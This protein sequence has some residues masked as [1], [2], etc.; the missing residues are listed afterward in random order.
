M[1]TL[2]M[3][4]A[5]LGYAVDGVTLLHDLSFELQAGGPTVL[6][7]S[8]GAGKSLTLRL[9][10]G[11]LAPTSGTIEWRAETPGTQAM[12]FQRP[13]ML[14]RSTVANVEYVL[15]VRGLPKTRARDVLDRVG[16]APLAHRAARALSVG[17]QQRLALARAWA[18]EPE[19]LFLDEPAASL[20]PA[21]S[22]AVEEIIRAMDGAGTKIVMA[23]H[24]L[25]QARRLAG[26]VLF[27]HAGRLLESGPADA[28]FAEPRTEEARAFLRGELTW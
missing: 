20:D 24:D 3:R 21:A 13:V 9:C 26:E 8:N 10:H 18:L 19:V 23:T 27:L 11:L 14:R 25:S 22:H 2:P 1:S 28:F 15:G 12:V 7:G 5:A 17:E 4:A 6:L 16:L